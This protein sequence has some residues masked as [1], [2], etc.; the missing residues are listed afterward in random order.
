MDT[1]E[2]I[3]IIHRVLIKMEKYQDIG[4]DYNRSAASISV[5]VAKAKKN[6]HFIDELMAEKD[7]LNKKKEDLWDHLDL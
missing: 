2:K 5:L 6:H 3:D 4:K 1:H 7:R